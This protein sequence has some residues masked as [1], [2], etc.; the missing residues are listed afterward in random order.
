MVN[1]SKN[2][3]DLSTAL[4]YPSSL[5]LTLPKIRLMRGKPIRKEM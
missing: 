3:G 1:V 2:H 5:L 4:F